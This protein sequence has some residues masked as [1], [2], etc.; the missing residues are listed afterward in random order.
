MAV[1]KAAERKVITVERTSSHC[2]SSPFSCKGVV[3][4]GLV[5]STGRGFGG[6]GKESVGEDHHEE[7]P[8]AVL[9]GEK[10]EGHLE[11]HH[12]AGGD[13]EFLAANGVGEGSRGD[14]EEKDGGGPD[15]VHGQEL[16]AT[17][18]EVEKED[19][20]DGVVGPSIVKNGEPSVESDVVMTE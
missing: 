17:E 18:P 14:F 1:K 20:E 16:F 7:N 11:N 3:G 9:R 5:G 12:H 2:F 15:R 4:E 6:S 8:A 10:E 13:E 19:G